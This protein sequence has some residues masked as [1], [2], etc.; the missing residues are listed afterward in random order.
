MTASHA[1][2]P[3]KPKGFNAITASISVANVADAVAFYTETLGA[4]AVETLTIPDTETVVYAALK[5]SG[6]TFVLT[7]DE[8]AQPFGG[9]GQVTLHHYLDDIEKVLEKAL[10]NG[11]SPVSAITQAWWGDKTAIIVD[12]FGVRWSL[13]QRAEQ[14]SANERTER[15]EALY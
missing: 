5:V 12:P 10:E 8:T 14:L 13:A 7:M 2:I 11:A 15:F 6:S 3:T 9:T 4:A 1:K